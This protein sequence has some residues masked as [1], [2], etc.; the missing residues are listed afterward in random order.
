MAKTTRKHTAAE[1]REHPLIT[2]SSGPLTDAQRA[3]IHGIARK[4]AEDVFAERIAAALADPDVKGS[5]SV[6]GYLLGRARRR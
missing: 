2:V 1:K 4:E 3:A 6:L 5:K